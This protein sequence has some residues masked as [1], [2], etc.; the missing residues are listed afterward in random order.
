MESYPNDGKITPPMLIGKNLSRM[1]DDA[2][3]SLR[4]LGEQVGYPASYISRVEMGHQLP[5]SALATALDKHFGTRDLFTDL[6]RMAQDS[7]VPNYGREILR[8]E[9][10]ATR[11]QVFSSSVIPGLLQTEAYARALI[12]A[13]CPKETGG[14]VDSLV[15]TRMDRK[16]V[17]ERDDP[18]FYWAI[19]DEAALKRPIGG[20]GAMVEQ[21]DTVLRLSEPPHVEVQVLPFSRG[22]HSMLGGSLVLLT[23]EPG[24]IHSATSRASRPGTS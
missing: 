14:R 12:R 11:I 10:K 22:E 7:P 17:F 20:K 23:L 21:L 13:S 15:D 4:G 6:L 8:N 9:A 3:L 1:R 16:H 24:A 18:P 2:E 19:M 5:S